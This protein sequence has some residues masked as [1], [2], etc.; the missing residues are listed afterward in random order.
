MIGALMM[1]AMFVLVPISSVIGD[2]LGYYLVPIQAMIFARI[3]FLPIRQN[4]AV[5]VAL[6]YIG[7][8]TV[9]VVW[10]SLS[11]HFQQCY[12]PYQTWLFGYP[13]FSRAIFEF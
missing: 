2:R 13:E 12:L 9:F 5:Y 6:P 1:A 7:L 8:L 3:P 10:T 11:W 4:R